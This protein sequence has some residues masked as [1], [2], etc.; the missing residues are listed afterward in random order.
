[1]DDHLANHELM[2]LAVVFDNPR[3]GEAHGESAF[4]LPVDG[5]DFEI[6]AGP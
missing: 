4:R 3:V 2:D 5:F 1:V 6:E